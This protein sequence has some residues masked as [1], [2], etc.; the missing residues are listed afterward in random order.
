MEK[1]E[2]ERQAGRSTTGKL[3]KSSTKHRTQNSVSIPSKMKTNFLKVNKKKGFGASSFR[4]KDWNSKKEDP[5]P[6]Q[7]KLYNESIWKENFASQ[8]RKGWGGFISNDL[9]IA[10]S[11]MYVNTGPG[12]GSYANLMEKKKHKNGISFAQA[13][14]QIQNYNLNLAQ[15]K[16]KFQKKKRGK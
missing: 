14:K 10:R 8:S 12:P 3:Y 15:T 16:Q 2:F 1:I 11:S 9:R 7:Y 4:F 5:G 13:S 6:G